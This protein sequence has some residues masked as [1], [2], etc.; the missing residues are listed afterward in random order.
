MYAQYRAY[1]DFSYGH[2]DD[3][4]G[5]SVPLDDSYLGEGEYR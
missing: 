5:A 1:D 3:V 2:F 4:T